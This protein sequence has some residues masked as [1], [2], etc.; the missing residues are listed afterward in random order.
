MQLCNAHPKP[1]GHIDGLPNEGIVKIMQPTI[2]MIELICWAMSGDLLSIRLWLTK[3]LTILQG[4]IYSYL[5]ELSR[6]IFNI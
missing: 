5:I 4:N 3:W 2:H 6:Y 1:N